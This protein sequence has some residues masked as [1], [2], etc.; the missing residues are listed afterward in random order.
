MSLK[1]TFSV[2]QLDLDTTNPRTNP[3]ENQTAAMNSLISVEKEGEKIYALAQDICEI[4][5]LDPGDRLY[6]IKS[7]LEA[8]RYVV[9]D[10]N[11]RLT[12][13][14]LLSQSGLL[15]RDDIGVSGSLRQRFKRLQRDYK[16][17]W[18]TEVDV[19]VFADRATANRFIRL[20][21]T[22]EN[23]GA[24]RSAWSALQ[25]A[26]F[27]GTGTWKCLESLRDEKTLNLD[28]LN[29]LERSEFAITNFDRVA[30]S[31]GFQERFGFSIG[32]NSFSISGD[33]QRAFAALSRLAS[34]VVIGLVDSRGDFAKAKDMKKYFDEVEAALRQPA[35]PSPAAAPSAGS[36][37]DDKNVST[38]NAAHHS[39]PRSPGNDSN[40]APSSSTSPI[41]PSTSAPP[42]PVRKKRDLKYL[43]EKR[44]LST[45][46][47]QKCRAIVEELKNTVQVGISPY[48][49]ALLLRSLQELTAQLYLE[50]FG[51][52][53]SDKSANIEQA[54]NHLLSKPH[55]TTD[56]V[57]RLE[58]AKSFKT[59]SATYGELSATAHSTLSTVS[60]DHVRA[61]WKNIGGGM[62]L[63]WKRIHATQIA[64]TTSTAV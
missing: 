35:S 23:S 40:P 47:N 51:L 2:S 41:A 19:V 56:P 55:P 12:A 3:E 63:L 29:Q 45:V 8:G 15:D 32:K 27:D 60:P 34:D 50:A 62:D 39:A 5:S 20:R 59:S 4:G 61:T 52:K 24:G 46:T 18:P 1:A 11:R 37:N 36:A 31:A 58:L 33:K 13:L 38:S 64:K 7:L 42:S 54:A 16:D 49:S 25:V 57:N 44:D 21:H 6:V 30:G 22:G 9:L 53:V 14:R 28:V 48:A 43:I 10:G 26:R 17:R